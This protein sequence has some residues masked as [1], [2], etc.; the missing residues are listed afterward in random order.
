MLEFSK[1][2]LTASNTPWS[3]ALGMAYLKPLLVLNYLTCS[4]SLHVGSR[5]SAISNCSVLVDLV[6]QV[7]T[8]A[9]ALAFVMTPR[10]ANK[11]S[12]CVGQRLNN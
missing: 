12:I 8:I 1:T 10:P 6:K 4:A 9:S 5:T 3:T 7:S 11:R 2:L